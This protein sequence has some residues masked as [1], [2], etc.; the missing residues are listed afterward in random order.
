MLSE[1]SRLAKQQSVQFRANFMPEDAATLDSCDDAEFDFAICMTNTL[2]NL[3]KN[4]QNQLVRRLKRVLKPGGQVYF[5]T[6]T[7]GSHTA[8]LASYEAIGLDV[9]VEGSRIVAAEGLES[10][11]FSQT[12]LRRLIVENGLELVGEIEPVAGIGLKAIA[13]RPSGDPA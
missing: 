9:K 3:P 11:A 1:A 12:S 8:R 7:E 6:Y 5:S 4:K 2:G 10:E 13:Q